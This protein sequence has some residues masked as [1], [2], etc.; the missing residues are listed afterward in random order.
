MCLWLS[1]LVI[2]TNPPG[3]DSNMLV[4]PRMRILCREAWDVRIESRWLY[5]VPEKLLETSKGS[6]CF[7]CHWRPEWMI[8]SVV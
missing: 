1:N 7:W 4:N 5:F 2:V 8:A 6:E 3:Q